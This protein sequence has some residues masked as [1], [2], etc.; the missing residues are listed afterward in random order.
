MEHPKTGPPMRRRTLV[1]GGL[2]AVGGLVVAATLPKPAEAA[3][4]MWGCGAPFGPLHQFLY[5]T[6]P[7]PYWQDL[8]IWR[9]SNWQPGATNPSSAAAGLCQFL[10]ST[11]EWGSDRFGL[12]GSPYNPYDAIRLM[13]AFIAAGEYYHWASTAPW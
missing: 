6:A 2:I 8:V 13:N 5:A 7:D 10:W 4:H 9:E 3:G 11:W 12:Y 1:R